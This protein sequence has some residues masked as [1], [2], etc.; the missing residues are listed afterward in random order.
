M[1]RQFMTG[2]DKF[3]NERKYPANEVAKIKKQVLQAQEFIRKDRLRAAVESAISSSVVPSATAAHAE[4]VEKILKL[5]G[6][7]LF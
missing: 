4:F 2:M 5:L 7:M 1:Y 3:L 6:I